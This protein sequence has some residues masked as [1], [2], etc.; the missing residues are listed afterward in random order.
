MHVFILIGGDTRMDLIKNS[1]RF[2]LFIT[3][4]AIISCTDKDVSLSAKNSS[5][6]A[7]TT[8]KGIIS[9]FDSLHVN[10]ILYT[11]GDATVTVDGKPA[12]INDLHVGMV[13]TVK[14]L[15]N[16]D[17]TAGIAK[18][19]EFSS[20]LKGPV[21]AV[22]LSS[23]TI[24][25][26]GQT[27]KVDKETFSV[28]FN[29]L[30]VLNRGDIVEVS[31]FPDGKGVIRSTYICKKSSGDKAQLNGYV[32]GILDKQ[33]MTVQIAD[34]TPPVKVV[35]ISYLNQSIKVGSGISVTIDLAESGGGTVT[36]TAIRSYEPPAINEGEFVIMDGYVTEF[37]GLQSFKVNGIKVATGGLAVTRELTVGKKV[38]VSGIMKYGVLQAATIENELETDVF[39][40]G[41]VESVAS[42]TL[43]LNIQGCRVFLNERTTFR[44]DSSRH[45]RD[46][47]LGGVRGIKKEDYLEVSGQLGGDS[48]MATKVVRR[49]SP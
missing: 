46:F 3:L 47:G 12:T 29:D 7:P 33:T 32:T 14:G 43:V 11:T 13:V 21:T 41:Q 49:N 4:L 26:L 38:S 44:D 8:A 45:E 9:G 27:I 34:G 48:I 17:R 30:S 5:V 20:L 37:K 25:V 15:I 19:V 36:A 18:S 10:G 22:D 42:G 40:G 31:G 1:A 2:A 35:S 24:S 16:A 6:S 23:G 28:N 39:L